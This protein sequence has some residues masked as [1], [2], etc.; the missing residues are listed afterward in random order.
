MNTTV[1]AASRKLL[2]SVLLP[3]ASVILTSSSTSSISTDNNNNDGSN[4]NESVASYS[5]RNKQVT[6]CE[7]VKK[8]ETMEEQGKVIYEKKGV[9][10]Q[11]RVSFP[12]IIFLHV[13]YLG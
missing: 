6:F 3:S 4:T 1:S 8:D 2:G 13:Y 9:I 12:I 5:G 7:A 11:K 10:L